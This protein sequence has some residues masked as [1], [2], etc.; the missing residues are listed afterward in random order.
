MTKTVAVDFGER[1]LDIAVPDSAV[2]AEFSDPE[3]AADPVAA[4]RQALAEPLGLPPLA[5][6]ARPGM[7]VAIGFDD[8][9]R[10]ANVARTL[11]AGI[12][13]VLEKSGI[14]ERDMLFVNACSN[15]RKNTRAE[16]SNHVGADLYNRFAP[17]GQLVNH[18]CDEADN[19]RFFGITDHGRLVEHN[20][21]YFDADLLVYQGN[22]SAQAWGGYTGTGAVIG[23][24]STRSIASHHSFH[25]IPNTVAGQ[26]KQSDK[27][28]PP[29]MKP[30]MTAVLEAATGKP[31]FYVN[32]ISGTQGRIVDVYA[33]HSNAI[34]GPSWK[35]AQKL[36]TKD[37][38][39]A[40][41]MIIGLAPAYSY[42]SANN[43]LI[44]AVGATVPPRY[45]PK[46]P[47]LREGGVVIAVSPSNGIID[48]ERFPSY[49]EL[50]ELYGRHFSVRSLVDYEA[51]FGQRPEYLQRYHHGY[52]YPPLH[53]FWIFYELEYALQRAGV[54]YLAGTSNPGAFRKLGIT[55]MA[56]FESAWK[57]AK[58]IVG[59][60]PQIVVAPTFW[61]RP[62]IKFSVEADAGRA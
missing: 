49:A 10:P 47:V 53:A 23:L 11:L 56:D 41:V 50:V 27:P 37:V 19:L 39:Q 36:F 40:D 32:A 9:T 5:E 6:M 43:A 21:R 61:S 22:V 20:K 55:P 33:G 16:L 14:R 38:P 13:E 35:R 31:I 46:A 42:G 15:H 58:R 29:G 8:I 62:R 59:N 7:R 1:K 57:A 12:V 34:V 18:D 48:P 44:A 52:G 28:K 51:E 30:E 17:L 25:A 4:V 60:D 3:F 45:S 24:A 54:V 26:K 2:I